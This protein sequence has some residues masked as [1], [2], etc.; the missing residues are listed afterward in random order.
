M[1]NLQRGCSWLR[2]G[3]LAGNLWATFPD[4]S[5]RMVVGSGPSPLHTSVLRDVFCELNVM[6]I[7]FDEIWMAQ[8]VSEWS[9]LYIYSSKLPAPRLNRCLKISG[10]NDKYLAILN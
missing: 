10:R 2:V 9:S 6:L 1:H 8:G 7:I 5:G 3:A 4:V